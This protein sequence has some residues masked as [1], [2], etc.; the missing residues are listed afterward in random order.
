MTDKCLKYDM[1]NIASLLGDK[2][3][4]LSLFIQKF[5]KPCLYIYTLF[6]VSFPVIP[7][8]Q[9]DNSIAAHV[10]ESA[11]PVD[12]FSLLAFICRLAK[13]AAMKGLSYLQQQWRS[14]TDMSKN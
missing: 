2:I 11:D 9:S 3:Y 6:V 10:K 7:V 12:H 8:K 14:T 1:L 5:S 4:F 13:Q